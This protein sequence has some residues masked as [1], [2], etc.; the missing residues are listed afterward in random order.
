MTMT[1]EKENLSPIIDLDRKTVIAVANRLDNVDTSSDVYPADEY[2]SP[3]EPDGDSGEAVYVTRKVQLKLPATA[4]KLFFSAVKFD[5][6]EIHAMY[7]ILRS[8]DASDFD[9]IGWEYFNT[10]GSP[11]TTVNSSI[12]NSDFIEREHT[13]SG[14]GD[15]IAFAIKIRMQGTNSSEVPRVKDLRAI[16]LAT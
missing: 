8:D 1:S 13:V 16:A 4:I 3:T 7:K 9:E 6:A 14:L 11:D 2:I 5:S 15:F 12:N 10:D